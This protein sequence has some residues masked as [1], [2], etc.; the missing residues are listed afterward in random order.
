MPAE[1]LK[2]C[3][4][5]GR[6]HKNG[7]SYSC[8]QIGPSKWS[9]I[10]DY[11]SASKPVTLLVATAVKVGPGCLST[12]NG[13]ADVHRTY[14]IGFQSKGLIDGLGHTENVNQFPGVWDS[15]WHNCVHETVITGKTTD[16]QLPY[17]INDSTPEEFGRHLPPDDL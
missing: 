8:H 16:I 11:R 5:S 6:I 12:N 4:H 14:A 3:H 1:L 10:N 13:S 2:N 9:L 7:K 15:L 17:K